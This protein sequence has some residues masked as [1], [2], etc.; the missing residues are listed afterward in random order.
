MITTKAIAKLL[1][2]LTASLVTA[3]Q[4]SV[5]TTIVVDEGTFSAGSPAP[6]TGAAYTQWLMGQSTSY[7]N[8]FE[9][10]SN[11]STVTISSTDGNAPSSQL[12][13]PSDAGDRYATAGNNFL[14]VESN[15]TFSVTPGL[16]LVTGFAV[17]LT[18]IADNAPNLQLIIEFMSGA[19]DTIDVNPFSL[20]YQSGSSMFLGYAGNTALDA[21]RSVTIQSDVDGFDFFGVDQA[22]FTLLDGVNQN[23]PVP[24]TPFLLLAGLA[25]LRRATN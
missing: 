5:V 16:G 20:L 1:L 11:P 17:Q 12:G 22:R 19:F 4:A 6:T 7:F 3:A 23:L 18:D 21:I 2:S 13:N 9:S 15:V 10:G 25:L 8:S 14:L 24:A